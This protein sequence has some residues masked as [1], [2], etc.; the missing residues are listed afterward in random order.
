MTEYEL[1]VTLEDV[2]SLQVGRMYC[3]SKLC[4]VLVPTS[5]LANALLSFATNLILFNNCITK[6]IKVV[7]WFL[8]CLY[9]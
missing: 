4:L 1:R 2:L 8:Q 6:K 5:C 9:L 7:H 3:L